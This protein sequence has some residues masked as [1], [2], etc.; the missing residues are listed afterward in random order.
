MAG[1]GNNE[2]NWS[3]QQQQQLPNPQQSFNFDM[4]EQFGGEL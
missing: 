4:P 3:Q 1:Y 2:Y